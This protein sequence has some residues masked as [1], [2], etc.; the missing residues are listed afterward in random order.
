MMKTKEEMVMKAQ[1]WIRQME[2]EIT[3][4]LEMEFYGENQVDLCDSAISQEPY[5]TL[6]MNG[7]AMVKL[8]KDN[9][10]DIADI[11]KVQFRYIMVS[12]YDRVQDCYAF[13]DG[14]DSSLEM[15]GTA[16]RL[17]DEEEYSEKYQE[18][19]FE[20]WMDDVIVIDEVFVQPEYRRN[21][22]GTAA[23]QMLFEWFKMHGMD[24]NV[25]VFFDYAEVREDGAL[26]YEETDESTSFCRSFGR[27]LEIVGGN[28][29]FVWNPEI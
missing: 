17:Y 6:M 11:A 28:R 23:I 24:V 16:L 18:I 1:E 5:N 25:F 9:G 2:E 29:I 20:D 3:L 10:Q 22:I 12:K 26:Y 4:V 13:L 7:A 8:S 14:D 19:G 15:I 21:G 27:L